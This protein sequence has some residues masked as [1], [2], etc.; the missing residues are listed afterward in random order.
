MHAL[1]KL[2]VRDKKVLVLGVGHTG[3]SVCKALVK[4]NVWCEMA[5]C[6][7]LC[8]APFNG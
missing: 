7:V 2:D 4:L 1:M 8:S 5:V 3:S 6:Q